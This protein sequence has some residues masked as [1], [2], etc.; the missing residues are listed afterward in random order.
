MECYRGSGCWQLRPEE[1]DSTE[2]QMAVQWNVTRALAVGRST[3]KKQY[4]EG[5]GGGGRG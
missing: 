2:R 5:E 3:P 1:A 4:G